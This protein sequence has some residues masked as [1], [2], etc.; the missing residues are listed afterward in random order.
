M[1]KESDMQHIDDFISELD[2]SELSYLQTACAKANAKEEA[3]EETMDSKKMPMKKSK[4]PMVPDTAEEI[5]LEDEEEYD[6]E[7]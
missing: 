4:K 2:P 6:K 5:P 1:A 3:D 7:A